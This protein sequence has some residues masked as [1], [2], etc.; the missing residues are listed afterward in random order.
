MTEEKKK[1]RKEDIKFIIDALLKIFFSGGALITIGS[2][3]IFPPGPQPEKSPIET[4][5][6]MCISGEYDS[7]IDIYEELLDKDSENKEVLINLGYAYAHKSNAEN[8]DVYLEKAE[9]TYRKSACTEGARNLLAL[10]LQNGQTEKATALI[11]KLLELDDDITIQFLNETLV[12]T[13]AMDRKDITKENSK[14]ILAALCE[15]E[16]SKRYYDGLSAPNDTYSTH[17][18]FEKISWNKAENGSQ[19]PY[20]TYKIYERRFAAHISEIE[21]IYKTVGDS[22]SPTN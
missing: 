17:Y 13:N 3:I 12:K 10:L 22:L 18:E 11:E 7:A 21:Y 19:M 9:D 14:S 15:F 5:R 20:S 8:S 16:D 4:A 1:E 6:E 2:I